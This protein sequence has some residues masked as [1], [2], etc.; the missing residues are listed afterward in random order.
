MIQRITET[1]ES[2][3][4]TQVGTRVCRGVKERING[5]KVRLKL[6]Y[7][8]NNYLGFPKIGAF[9]ENMETTPTKLKIDPQ[10]DKTSKDQVTKEAD[11][12]AAVPAGK[13]DVF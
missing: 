6:V 2:K 13:E 5:K 12:Q 3:K 1:E 11:Q 4:I 8:K 10:Y 9:I 7:D